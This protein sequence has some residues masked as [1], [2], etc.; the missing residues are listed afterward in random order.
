MKDPVFD[1][2]CAEVTARLKVITLG[3]W[4]GN[5]CSRTAPFEC[6]G[7]VVHEGGETAI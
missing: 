1:K 7:C 2:M 6:F 4:V 5:V 3:S